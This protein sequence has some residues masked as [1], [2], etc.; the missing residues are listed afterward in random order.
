MRFIILSKIDVCIIFLDKKRLYIESC[1][2]LLRKTWANMNNNK[3]IL[4]K[5]VTMSHAHY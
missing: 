2:Q 5:N 4:Y 1:Y 3:F